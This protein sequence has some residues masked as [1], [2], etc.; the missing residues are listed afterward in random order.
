MTYSDCRLLCGV[1][2]RLFKQLVVLRL[3]WSGYISFDFLSFY[4]LEKVP[5][6]L[7]VL[8]YRVAHYGPHDSYIFMQPSVQILVISC[9]RN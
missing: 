8:L 6:K 3:K 1:L 4:S 5:H 9:L 2:S 7:V